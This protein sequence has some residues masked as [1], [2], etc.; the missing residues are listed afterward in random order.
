[1]HVYS[2]GCAGIL[3]RMSAIDVAAKTKQLCALQVLP[4]SSVCPI[5]YLSWIGLPDSCLKIILHEYFEIVCCNYL[6]NLLLI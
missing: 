6:F 3:G 5:I 2:I 1:M 4:L